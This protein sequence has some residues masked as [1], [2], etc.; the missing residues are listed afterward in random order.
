[1]I[2]LVLFIIDIIINFRTTY[3]DEHSAEIV[4]AKM[5]A[6]KYFKS[7]FFFMDL[8]SIIPFELLINDKLR[9]L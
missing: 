2:I 7:I 3:F 4:D 5:I 1:M 9:V 6:L 8:I